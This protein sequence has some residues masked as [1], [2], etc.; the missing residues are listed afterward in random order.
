M[1]PPAFD[2]VCVE[3]ADEAVDLLARHGDE[4][5]ILAGGQSLLP[6]LN[7]RLAMPAVLIDI[8]RC[9][10]LSGIR[11]AGVLECGAAITQA[12]LERRAGLAA[13]CPMLVQALPFISHFQIRSR[14]TV[15]GSIAH[16]EPTA[17]LPLVLAALGGRVCL[18]SRTGRRELAAADF[19]TGM[20]STDR[21]A[22]ELIEGVRFPLLQ[23]QE[24]QGFAEFARRQGD[25]AIVAIAASVTPARIRL[26]VGG[27][28]DRPHVAEWPWLSGSA[29]D[30]ALNALAWSLH[31]RDDAQVSATQRR[32]LVRRLGRD[33][34]GVLQS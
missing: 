14:G 6:V 16:A 32:R 26:A 30:D 8:S 3:S 5:R 19:Q 2:Y 9:D 13:E 23:A 18:R 22:D 1:K 10:D 31:A 17:E 4:A 34:I 7:M 25:Y 27:V 29:L 12:T 24:R 11:S 15:C 28:E 33:L 20:L 21:R